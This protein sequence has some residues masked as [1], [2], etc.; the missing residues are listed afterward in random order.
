MIV[1]HRSHSEPYTINRTAKVFKIRYSKDKKPTPA[2]I[3]YVNLYLN[4]YYLDLYI[5]KGVDTGTLQEETLAITLALGIGTS[6][7]TGFE[8]T[9][10]TTPT[11]E[12]QL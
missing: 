1:L 12:V 5:A 6:R 11:S 2:L 9:K 4:K 8:H 7:T 10:I 3:G